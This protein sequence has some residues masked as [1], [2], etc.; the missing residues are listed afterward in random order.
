[1]VGWSGADGQERILEDVFGAKKMI[2][3]KHGNRTPGQKELSWGCEE[4]LV[5]Y[6]GVG[7]VKSKGGLQ[8]DFDMLQMTPKIPEAL[9]LSR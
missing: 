3:L 7:E 2:L 5:L 4:W 8:K 9:L 6:Y 1:M